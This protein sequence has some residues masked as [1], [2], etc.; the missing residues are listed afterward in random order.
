[1]YPTHSTNYGFDLFNCV[2]IGYI[3]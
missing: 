2:A 3:I 1:L